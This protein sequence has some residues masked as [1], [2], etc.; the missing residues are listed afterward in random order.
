MKRGVHVR[1]RVDTEVDPADVGDVARRQRHDPLDRELGVA[2]VDDH[3]GSERDGDIVDHA[4][5][6]ISP[7]SSHAFCEHHPDTKVAL[8]R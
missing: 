8:D 6:A 5:T 2:R 3:P 7:R 1:S 4:V